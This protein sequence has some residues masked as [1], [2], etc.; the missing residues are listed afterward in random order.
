[1][2]GQK[3]TPPLQEHPSDEPDGAVLGNYATSAYTAA[4]TSGPQPE[5]RLHAGDNAAPA[6]FPVGIVAGAV[7]RFRGQPVSCEIRPFDTPI[8]L[9]VSATDK[10]RARRAATTSRL[11]AAATP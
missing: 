7:R 10:P 4:L 5:A 1:M 11:F 6:A 8:T 9:A 3:R 2:R